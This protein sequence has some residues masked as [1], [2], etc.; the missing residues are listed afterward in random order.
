[1]YLCLHS[2]FFLFFFYTGERRGE[3]R[4]GAQ[5]GGVWGGGGVDVELR[6]FLTSI[7]AVC[8]WAASRSGRISP[9]K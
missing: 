6:S 5:P 4:P 7:L 9:E 3:N 8:V 2:F 1:V